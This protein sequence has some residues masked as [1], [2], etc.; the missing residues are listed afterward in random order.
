[1]NDDS[2]DTGTC[3]DSTPSS[4]ASE[5]TNV[6]SDPVLTNLS[7]LGGLEPEHVH[8]GLIFSSENETFKNSPELDGV[9]DPLPPPELELETNY[10]PPFINSSEIDVGPNPVLISGVMLAALSSPDPELEPS[11]DWNP[12]GF[13]TDVELPVDSSQVI[14]S[15]S[16]A[17]QELCE[18]IKNRAR[19]LCSEGQWMYRTDV[20]CLVDMFLIGIPA[21]KR[22]HYNCN[23]CRSFINRFGGLVL[24]SDDGVISSVMWSMLQNP[25][26]QESILWMRRAIESATV[27]GVFIPESG[28]D[29]LGTPVTGPWTHFHCELPEG[30]GN[31]SKV[32]TAHQLEAEKAEEFKMLSRFL[33]GYKIET[34][35]EVVRVLQFGTLPGG[36]KMIGAAIWLLN[37]KKRV[38]TAY[39]ERN[40]IWKAV[41]TGPVGFAHVR[42]TIVGELFELVHS[43]T[44]YNDI[45]LRLQTMTDPLQYQRPQTAPTE[46][47]VKRAEE[48]IEKM[49]LASA[50]ERRYLRLDEVVK[51]WEPTPDVAPTPKPGI[52]GHLLTKDKSASEQQKIQTPPVKMTWEKFARTVLPS[53]DKMDFYAEGSADYIALVGAVNPDSACLFKWD[54]PER[55]H[56]VNWYVYPQGSSAGRWHLKHGWVNVT[57]VTSLPPHWYEPDKHQQFAKSVILLLA[58]AWDSQHQ[59]ASLFPVTLR[60]ELHEVRA[61]IEAY[62]K[63]ASLLGGNVEQATACG[64]RFNEHFG[65]RL[66]VFS[67]Q[68]WAEYVIDRLD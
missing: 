53:A 64:V 1:M 39:C 12:T 49:G 28:T 46:G 35:E 27:S 55:R 42:S 33:G 19:H 10:A 22:Q 36:E 13:T 17:Y 43:G 25:F 8:T 11:S 56:Q 5:P 66:R 14:T 23:A 60:S 67:D 9:A 2:F 15:D 29:V 24:I 50:L 65:Y 54:S 44:G 37:L 26:F 45:Y 16:L 47:N 18:S 7:F 61:T 57:A 21:N 31:A 58:G 52:F 40:V 38:A 34:F 30:Y 62:S 63:N 32:K 3:L 41:A 48:L 20:T 6:G 59:G 4:C 51:Q 68:A